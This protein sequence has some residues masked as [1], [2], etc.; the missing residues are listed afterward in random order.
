MQNHSKPSD[1]GATPTIANQKAHQNNTVAAYQSSLTAST[2]QMTN[3]TSPQ[4]VIP[5]SSD[6]Q[7]GKTP[8]PIR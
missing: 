2:Y 6:M 1:M 5:S 7:I 8:D 4:Y 3:G